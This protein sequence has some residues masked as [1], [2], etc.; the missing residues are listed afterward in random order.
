MNADPI[1]LNAGSVAQSPLP[2]NPFVGLRPF[3]SEESVLFFGRDQQ[4]VELM[5]Q[6]HR[7]H[8]LAVVGSSGCGKSSLIRAGLIP[9][10]KAGLLVERHERWEGRDRW[11]VVAAK[12][13]GGARRKKAGG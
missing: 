5:R 8:F 9:T 2:S 1:F 10:L 7:T 4:I 13:R 11:P 12:K 6:L 3:E